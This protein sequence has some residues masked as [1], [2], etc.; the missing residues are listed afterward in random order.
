MIVSR[1]RRL[2]NGFTL[3]E[4]LLA[5]IVF[6]ACYI[7]VQQSVAGSWRLVRIAQSEESALAIAQ[8][9]LAVAGIETPLA[10]GTSEGRT[11]DGYTWVVEI[12]RYL[13]PG[14][15]IGV[16]TSP[17]VAFWVDVTVRWQDSVLRPERTLSL[18]TLRLASPQVRPQ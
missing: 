3:I 13:P 8:R 14:S 15:E 11:E 1:S 17:L 10:A 4:T 16:D 12:R 18:K 6:T 2:E 9:Q 7:L 5:L